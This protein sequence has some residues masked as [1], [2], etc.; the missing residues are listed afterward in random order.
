MRKYQNVDVTAVLGAVMELNTEH[1]KSDFRYDMEMFREAA[2]NPDGENDRLL[3]LS[4]QSGTECFFE[5]EAYLVESHAHSSWVYHATNHSET[6]LAY[7]VH[8]KGT[9][10]G[11]I[12][13][14]IIE[15]DY[16]AHAKAVERDALHVATVTAVYADGAELH[17]PYKEWDGQRE[18]LFY[19][20]GEL[21]SLRRKPQSEAALTATLKA[22]RDSRE[23]QARPAAFKLRVEAQEKLSIKEQL[24]DGKKQI[25]KSRATAPERVAAAAKSKQME[26]ER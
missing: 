9:E 4:R 22:A 16:Q 15:L 10:D 18:R 12:K 19:E 8:I 6:P 3:W 2:R 7:A 5:R 21:T 24:A 23:K 1:Y 17:L 11:R 13:G 20:H 14:D 26:V 25:E